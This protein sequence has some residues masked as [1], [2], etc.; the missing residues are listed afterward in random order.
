MEFDTTTIPTGTT[1]VTA[2]YKGDDHFGTSTSPPTPLIVAKAPTIVIRTAS[3]TSITSGS[4]VTITAGAR[5][6]GI[7]SPVGATGTMT[8]Y[9][10]STVLGS[11]WRSTRRERP[12]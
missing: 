8:F 3:A 5:V 11:P 4:P 2:V 10:G 12:S 7:V 6:F 1:S 9:E